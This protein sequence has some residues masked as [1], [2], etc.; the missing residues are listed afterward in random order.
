MKAPD[1]APSAAPPRIPKALLWLF[2][3]A[4]LLVLAVGY[5]LFTLGETSRRVEKVRSS[6]HPGMTASQVLQNT[7]GWF[8]FYAA[9]LDPAR[10]DKEVSVTGFREGR[11]Y[12]H[13][14]EPPGESLTEAELL[15]RIRDMAGG[16]KWK[17]VF[18][19]RGSSPARHS[20]TVVFSPEDKV[21]EI[22]PVTA[23]D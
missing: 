23:R 5:G 15:A 21:V 14:L 6:L 17:L 3:A 20:F 9:A 18:T 19:Y 8:M 16:G 10:A 7:T 22:S 2:G 4:A 11:F 1:A 13:S 12:L